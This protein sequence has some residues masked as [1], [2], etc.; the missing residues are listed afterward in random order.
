MSSYKV[1]QHRLSHRGRSFHFV[2]YEGAPANPA[3]ALPATEPTWFMM[4]AG[5]RWVVMPHHVGQEPAELDRLFAAWL[6]SNV[7]G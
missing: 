4:S 7:F 3:K 5:K 1:E 6:D 2:S